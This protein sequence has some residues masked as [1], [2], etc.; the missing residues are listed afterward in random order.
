P[1]FI[2]PSSHRLTE[3]DATRTARSS[4]RSLA[5]AMFSCSIP[6][7]ESFMAEKLPERRNWFF[8][9]ARRIS[10]LLILATAMVFPAALQVS[11]VYTPKQLE[12]FSSRIGKTFWILSVDNRTPVFLSRPVAGATSFKA[13]PTESFVI[14]ELVGQKT[15]TL[16]Y[17]V[18]FE[19]DKEGY[20]TPEAFH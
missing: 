8:S 17:R 4:Y 14:T 9:Q 12:A 20:I 11:A 5:S 6:I 7:V 16:Y 10:R 18:K 19:S 1:L 13:G 3:Y 2:F 15:N